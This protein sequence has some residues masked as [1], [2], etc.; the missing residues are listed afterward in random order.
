MT[1][2]AV[3][4]PGVESA[5]PMDPALAPSIVA[6]F[7]APATQCNQRCPRC[8]ITEVFREPVHEFDLLPEHYVQ[9]LEGF[10][11]AGVPIAMTCFQGYEV[12]L[13]RSWP[14]VEAVFGF[15][16]RHGIRRSFVTNGMLLHKRTD[17]ILDLQPHRIAV[18]LDGSSAHINDRI[19]GLAG[20]FESTVRSLQSFIQ[21][22]PDFRQRLAVVSILYPTNL[23][24]LLAMPT[25]LRR[26]GVSHW[27]LGFELEAVG[28]SVRPALSPD[29]L[30]KKLKELQTASRKAGLACHVGDEFDYLS[31][32]RDAR[33]LESHHVSDPDFWFRLDPR[34]HVR[35]GHE[36]AEPWN[37][38]YR[39]WDP[40]R[41]D[42]IALVNYMR[43]AEEYCARADVI[44]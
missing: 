22:A 6:T 1:P 16:K 35:I 20:A 43:R 41:D 37:P 40:A 9:F 44:R 30:A 8:A 34:G 11:N 15:A 32:A 2:D 26:L 28:T 36:I 33:S 23:E 38:S 19:R 18:S 10:R 14:Y 27:I 3:A 31:T 13:P 17:R 25:L 7:L 12:T 21:A 39:R 5:N 42:P 4:A 24:S 29:T